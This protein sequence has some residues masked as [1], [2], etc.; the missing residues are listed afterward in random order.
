MQ[1][2]L[3]HKHCC[4]YSQGVLHHI[5]IVIVSEAFDSVEYL[6]VYPALGDDISGFYS[7]H[8]NGSNLIHI[9][10]VPAG[11]LEVKVTFTANICICDELRSFQ[12]PNSVKLDF[13]NEVKARTQY[14]VSYTEYLQSKIDSI[15]RD[16]SNVTQS[17]DWVPG[18]QVK[19]TTAVCNVEEQDSTDGQIDIFPNGLTA[20]IPDTN[21]QGLNKRSYDVHFPHKTVG[22]LN[23]TVDEFQFTGPDRL[24]VHI[25]NIDQC[26][27]I[28][29]TIAST[30]LPNY[31]HA[32]IPLTSGLNIQEWEKQLADYP[33]RMLLEYLKFGFPLSLSQLE[34]LNNTSITNHHS[35]LQYPAA[36][37]DY[38]QKE[39]SLGAIIVP[40][41]QVNFSVVPRMKTKEG[42][43]LI[44]LTHIG[45]RLM[46]GYLGTNLMENILL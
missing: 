11:I 40:V 26:L 24:P 30:G 33:D 12:E 39:I 16:D 10:N 5:D 27:N 20:H 9:S 43:S 21:A 3:I 25:T 18:S 28:A 41:D 37:D 42:S 4:A 1:D 15:V 8:S 45:T 36:V 19:I 6:F 31:P 13:D 7:L 32:R 35:A 29:S 34:L 23:H 14:G 44:S 2:K 22:F 46:T 38:L 17:D